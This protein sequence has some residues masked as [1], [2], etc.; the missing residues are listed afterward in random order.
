MRLEIV[1]NSQE[2]IKLP[3]SYNH[4]LQ[5]FIYTLFDSALR[6]F[7]HNQGFLYEKR[8]FK[9]FCF[10]RLFGRFEK[11]DDTIS[12]IPPVRFFLSSPKGE[13]LQSLVE[14]LIKREELFLGRNK[15]FLETIKILPKLSF[16]NET[17][18]KMLSPITIYSTLKEDRGS[19]KT[20]YYSPYEERFS[21][22]IKENLRKKYT[23]L[24]NEEIK[25]IDFNIMPFKVSNSDQK[26]ILYKKQKTNQ[27]KPTVIKAWMGL[28]KIQ[29]DP[30]LIELSYDCG[31]GAKNSQGFGMWE[32]IG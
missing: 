17:I 12:F 2:K 20:H 10:S 6:K 27:A 28:Y 13:I 23:A 1:L 26:V 4:L 32:R 30:R 29:G 3:Y 7:L 9:F 8:K 22:L 18:I 31:L 21:D 14:G 19:K 5:G 25:D 11:Q 24:F 15:V 16:D